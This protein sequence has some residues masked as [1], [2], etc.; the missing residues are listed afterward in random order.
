M[1]GV[2]WDLGNVLLE[3]EPFAAVAAGVGESEARRFFAG[4]DFDAWNHRCDAGLPWEDALAQLERDHPEWAPHG[5]AYYENFAASLTGEVPGTVDLLRDLHDA[6]LPQCGLTNWSDELFH[7]HALQRFPFLGLLDD[8]VVSGTEGVAK[9]EGRIY[10][11]AAERCGLP[12][13]S[14]A[15]VDDKLANVEGAA[16]LG[17]VGVHFSDAATLRADLRALGLPV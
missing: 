13:A 7:T 5:H 10:A 14:L 6:G 8:V 16:A 1:A 15:F 4:F 17:M 9:P 3:W 11:I 2:V 12:L